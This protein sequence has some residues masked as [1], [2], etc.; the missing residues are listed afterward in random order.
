[1]YAMIEF[2]SEE[3]FGRQLDVSHD[4]ALANAE[5]VG[6]FTQETFSKYW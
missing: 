1:M 5:V 3:I 4:A 2:T 6:N